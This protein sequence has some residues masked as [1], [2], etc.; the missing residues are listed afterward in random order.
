MMIFSQ[1]I[2][3]LGTSIKLFG[4][5]DA[6]NLHDLHG[7]VFPFL[8]RSVRLS[9]CYDDSIILFRVRLSPY[10]V[11]DYPPSF[12]VILVLLLH[13]SVLA[14][15]LRILWGCPNPNREWERVQHTEEY[16]ELP[17]KHCRT[18]HRYFVLKLLQECML[19]DLFA[20]FNSKQLAMLHNVRL[21][22][23]EHL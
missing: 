20:F 19:L 12:L 7:V 21:I 13:F 10:R 5:A 2:V 3:V 1:S 9:V 18:L 16:H 14:N 4:Y 23:C 11:C 22:G 8:L 15:N 6:L 17:P